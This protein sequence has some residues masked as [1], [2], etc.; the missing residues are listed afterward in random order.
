MLLQRQVTSFS[1]LTLQVLSV[2]NISFSPYN[3]NTQ[4]REQLKSLQKPADASIFYQISPTNSVRKCVKITTEELSDTQRL[5]SRKYM[6]GE[7]NIAKNLLLSKDDSKLIDDI[8]LFVYCFRRSCNKFPTIFW[9]LI[10]HISLPGLLIL[11]SGKLPTYSSPK[12]TLTF[13]SYLGQNVD[14]G[15]R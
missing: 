6:F 8:V 14:L 1:R 12:L 10:I 7:T 15:K 11:V 13:G 5:L 3:N 2:T 9:S 4:I